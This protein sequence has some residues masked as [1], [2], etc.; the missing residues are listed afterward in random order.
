[1]SV[2]VLE[3]VEPGKSLPSPWGGWWRRLRW[4]MIVVG[5]LLGHF[6]LMM[7]ALYMATGD[8][9]GVVI[10]DSYVK[11]LEWDRRKAEREM[12]V[13]A[14][15]RMELALRPGG[16]DARGLRRVSLRMVDGS[17]EPLAATRASVLVYHEAAPGARHELTLTTERGGEFE[18]E[19][20]LGFRGYYRM[21]VRAEVAGGGVFV[22]EDRPFVAEGPSVRTGGQR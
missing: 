16:P 18:A 2:V 10:P 4:P 21:E 12:A 3:R 11:S 1:M 6:C 14:G 22:A 17:G 13:A 5:L 20:P 7:W 15:W 19:L 9:D 8:R